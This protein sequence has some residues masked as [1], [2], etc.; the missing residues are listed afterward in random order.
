MLTSCNGHREHTKPTEHPSSIIGPLESRIQSSFRRRRSRINT[1][2][3]NAEPIPC[4][5]RRGDGRRPAVRRRRARRQQMPDHQHVS[6][7]C[8]RVFIPNVIRA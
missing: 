4:T 2:I 6:G 1:H 5:V 8:V 3:F 7:K